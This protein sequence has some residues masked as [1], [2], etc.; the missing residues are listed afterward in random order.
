MPELLRAGKPNRSLGIAV[1]DGKSRRN[2]T[3][4]YGSVA[5]LVDAGLGPVVAR[6]PQGSGFSR[7]EGGGGEPELQARRSSV[8]YDIGVAE[9]MQT[10]GR[11]HPNISLPVLEKRVYAPRDRSVDPRESLRMGERFPLPFAEH[12]SRPETKETLFV[13]V[14]SPKVS[15][16]VEQQRRADGAAERHNPVRPWVHGPIHA[17]ELVGSGGPHAPVR[18]YRQRGS[19]RIGVDPAVELT[20]TTFTCGPCEKPVD[21]ADPQGAGAIHHDSVRSHELGLAGHRLPP[22]AGEASQ[23]QSRHRPNRAVPVLGKLLHRAVG[24]TVFES[25]PRDVPALEQAHARRT[26]ADP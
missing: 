18:R 5:D 8:A 26:K 14:R 25:I 1:G 11:T 21:G 2:L 4:D 3:T 9:A 20:E 17:D 16:G 19:A 15:V 6:Y 22:L 24:Q 13:S 12:V 7:R 10:G 23:P